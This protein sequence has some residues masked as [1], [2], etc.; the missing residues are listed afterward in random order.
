[1]HSGSNAGTSADSFYRR[2]DLL[3]IPSGQGR[4]SGLHA[5]G[6]SPGLHALDHSPGLHG[7]GLTD[8]NTNILETMCMSL[9]DIQVKLSSIQ[10]QN[11]VRDA[12]INRIQEDIKE[13]KGSKRLADD[14]SGPKSKKPKKSP[15]GLSVSSYDCCQFTFHSSVLSFTIGIGAQSPCVIGGWRSVSC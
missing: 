3:P 4:A 6:H 13:I 12:T 15:C 8:L 7:Q 9:S 10:D 11:L 2:G 1:M 14:T 5:P